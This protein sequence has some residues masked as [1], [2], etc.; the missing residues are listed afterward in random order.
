M[1]AGGVTTSNILAWDWHEWAHTVAELGPALS[2]T[3]NEG[4]KLGQALAQAFSG[5]SGPMHFIGH[6]LGTPVNACAADYLLGKATLA[7]NA[8][9]IQITSLDDP[10][11][12]AIFV[13][14]GRVS[15]A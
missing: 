1:K 12:A 6:S 4:E 9:R 11:L 15:I 10:G 3:P 2:R 14:L 13:G 5:Q 8:H 7:F